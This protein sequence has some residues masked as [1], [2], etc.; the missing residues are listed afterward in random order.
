MSSLQKE[1]VK[2]KNPALYYL[3]VIV[4]VAIMFLGK[5]VTP[6]APEITPVGMGV[7]GVF[8]GVVILWSSV[9]GSIWP[10]ILAIV[11]LACTGYCDINTAISSSLGAFMVFNILCV[12]AMTSAL[13]AS[14]AD[15]KMARWLITRKL[16]IGKPYLF[17]FVF[18]FAFFLISSVTFAL[19]MIFICWTILRKMAEEVGVSMRHPYFV[20]MTIYAVVATSL[21]EFVIPVK[22]WQYALCNIFGKIAGAPA[23]IGL[24]IL[25]TFIIGI[26]LMIIMVATMKPLFKVDFTPIA[27]YRPENVDKSQYRLNGAQLTILIVLILSMLLSIFTNFLKGDGAFATAMTT[28]GLPGIFGLAMVLLCVIKTKEGKPVLEFTKV[29]GGV[30]WAPII[31]VGIATCLSSAL[32]NSACGFMDF[33]SRTLVPL[34]ADKSPFVVY[35]FVI[36]LA[37]VLTNVASNMGIGMMMIPVAVP[38][39]MAAGCN[40]SVAAIAVMYTACFGFILPGAAAV[41]PLMY[42]NQDLKK[43]EILKVTSFAVVLYIIVGVIVFPVLDLL[44]R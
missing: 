5:Y 18:L 8:V 10:S 36:I 19:A 24:Y 42:S 43:P 30:S 33:F 32:T 23:N 37:V 13:T 11:A 39:F 31:L 9:G 15:Q 1:N 40:M 17:T 26:V 4:C 38:I 25:V 29:M 16:W 41:S 2:K 44:L 27:N 12:C 21:G 22:G 20:V 35:A 34:M 3:I 28:L 14:G 6:F 7:L